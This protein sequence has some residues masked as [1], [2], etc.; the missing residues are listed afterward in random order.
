MHAQYSDITTS[1]CTVRNVAGFTPQ[2]RSSRSHYMATVAR[3]KTVEIKQFT[4]CIIY[5]QTRTLER[6]SAVFLHEL[7]QGFVAG[8]LLL[9]LARMLLPRI[10]LLAALDSTG[11]RSHYIA[12]GGQWSA[13]LAVVVVLRESK[14]TAM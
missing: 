7:L 9:L 4:S 13:Y 12:D 5:Q 1:V 3:K 8:S 10:L 2:Q 11:S 6:R 14:S